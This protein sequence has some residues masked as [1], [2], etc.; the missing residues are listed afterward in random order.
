M[1]P[2]DGLEGGCECSGVRMHLHR[3]VL[4]LLLV[5]LC[6]VK[7]APCRSL[8]PLPRSS[9]EEVLHSLMA[10][11]LFCGAALVSRVDLLRVECD[12]MP[13]PALSL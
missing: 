3:L 5:C 1:L 13:I 8:H 9:A 6:F 7:K 12:S 10:V 4:V 2:L 11:P